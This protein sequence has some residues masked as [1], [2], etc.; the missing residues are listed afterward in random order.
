MGTATGNRLKK[1][2]KPM[3]AGRGDTKVSTELWKRDAYDSPAKNR[4]PNKKV[5]WE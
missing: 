3:V 2:E 1:N 4:V 5:G